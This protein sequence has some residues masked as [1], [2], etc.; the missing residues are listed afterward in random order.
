MTE[1]VTSFADVQ[2]Q[3]DAANA[4]VGA[5]QCH[6]ML[7]GVLCAKRA[8]EPDLWCEQI[9]GLDTADFSPAHPAVQLVANLWEGAQQQLDSEDF[10]FK[11]LLPGE[12]NLLSERTRGLSEWCQGFLFGYGAGIGSATKLPGSSEEFLADL[13]EFCRVDDEQAGSDNADEAAYMELV[14]YV[15][16][17]AL[18]LREEATPIVLRSEMS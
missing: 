11:L 4:L 1:R 8:W 2:A 3:L 10:S 16:A 5:A 6:G 12:D 9:A 13:R 15:R 17:G 14:E 18:L 7:C